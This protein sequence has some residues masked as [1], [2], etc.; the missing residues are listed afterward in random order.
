MQG[1]RKSCRTCG[2]VIE[3]RKKWERDWSEVKYCSQKC[4]RTKPGERE[5]DLERAILDLLGKRARNATICPSEVARA[6]FPE[7][8]WRREM[9]SV[10]QAARRLVD[11]GKI[12]MKQKG[13]VVDPSRAK[14]AVRLGLV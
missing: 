7:K 14:G 3:W 5:A 2:R 1:E 4:R 11:Q 9:E 8:N 12:V 13:Q 10:R 6:A